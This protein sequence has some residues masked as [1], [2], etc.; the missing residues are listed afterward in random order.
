MKKHLFQIFT[1]LAMLVLF[2][3][4]GGENADTDS[5][6]AADMAADAAEQLTEIPESAAAGDAICLWPKVGLRDAAGTG[7]GIKYLATVSFGEAVSPTGETEEVGNANFL[8]VRL[9]DGKEGWVKES[10]FAENA[11]VYVSTSEID[12]YPRP[13]LMTYKGQKFKRGDIVAVSSNEQDEWVEVFG[14]EKKTKGWIRSLDDLSD[15]ELDVTVGVLFNRAITEGKKADKEKL[16]NNIASN[17]VFAASGMMDVVDEALSAVA[18]PPRPELPANQAYILA[19]VLNV[20]SEPDTEQDNVS[21]QVKSGDIVEIVER[22]DQKAVNGMNDYWYLVRI[23]G[24]EG[25]IYGAHTS[26]KLE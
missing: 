22:G 18:E 7:N 15:A 17:S 4:C 1:L 20:R 26:K 6:A 23:D 25:W 19:D 24:Q 8:Q 11:M 3:A 5:N 13:D 2:T 14:L 12:V 9:S 10:L 21:F 16:L